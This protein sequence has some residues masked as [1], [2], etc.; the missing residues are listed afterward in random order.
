MPVSLSTVIVQHVREA[1]NALVIGLGS[2]HG[3]CLHRFQLQEDTAE[4]LMIEND[5]S[6]GSWWT[7]PLSCQAHF[8]GSLSSTHTFV[9]G[10]ARCLCH[11]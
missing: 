2:W 3:V 5:I 11:V 7:D 8:S 1:S 9:Y 6:A 10:L 4:L